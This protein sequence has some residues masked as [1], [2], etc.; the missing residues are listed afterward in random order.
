M[1]FDYLTSSRIGRALQSDPIASYFTGFGIVTLPF[2]LLNISLAGAEWHIAVLFLGYLLI[3]PFMATFYI[4]HYLWG[5]HY[6]R[7]VRKDYGPKTL[8]ALIKFYKGSEL[9]VFSI[10]DYARSVGEFK[11]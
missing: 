4:A 2:P 3:L 9:K 8:G 10:E 1:T 7:C 5:L 11:N 6:Q